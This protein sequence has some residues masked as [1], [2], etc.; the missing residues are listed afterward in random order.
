M[1]GNKLTDQDKSERLEKAILHAEAKG[2]KCLSTTYVNADQTIDWCCKNGHPFKSRYRA[3]MAMGR[4]CPYCAM[5]MSERL[6]MKIAEELFGVA[7]K[8]ERPDWL[9]NPVTNAPLE[10]DGINEELKLAIEYHGRQ[11]FED[12]SYFKNKTQLL[13]K[14]VDRDYFKKRKVHENGYQLIEVPYTVSSD[15]LAGFFY[16][17]LAYRAEPE[18]QALAERIANHWEHVR[19]EGDAADNP[20]YPELTTIAESK[21]WKIVNARVV[22][23]CMQYELMCEKGHHFHLKSSNLRRKKQC[24]ACTLDNSPEAIKARAIRREKAAAK[25]PGTQKAVLKKKKAARIQKQKDLRIA[26][27]LLRAQEVAKSRGGECLST[28]YTGVRSKMKWR[29]AKGHE[30]ENTFSKVVGERHTWCPVCNGKDFI[31]KLIKAQIA[32]EER[33][34]EC[35]STE[36]TGGHDKMQWRCANGHEWSAVYTAVVN[37]GDWCRQCSYDRRK[38]PRKPVPDSETSILQDATTQS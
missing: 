28:E 19:T 36:Y 34:G 37:C 25:R 26:G 14:G 12:I 27:G 8:K 31:G 15:E 24:T 33:G 4:W 22:E 23:Q 16:M 29:C 9:R 6:T 38:G 11:H 1:A 20:Q 18:A 7:F 5:G 17:A 21:G 30:W 13:V 2:G 3:V 10:L 35:L 32:A